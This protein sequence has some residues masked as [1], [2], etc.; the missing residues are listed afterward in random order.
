[1]PEQKEVGKSHSPSFLIFDRIR[2]WQTQ[3]EKV[4]NKISSYYLYYIL[5]VLKNYVSLYVFIFCKY[6]FSIFS[7]H[8][9]TYFCILL[10]QYN[11]YNLDIFER[12]K[13]QSIK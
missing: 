9:Q 12:T 3:I 7:H 13:Y 5:L 8:S 1:M 4:K 6:A 11:S 10:F 2:S